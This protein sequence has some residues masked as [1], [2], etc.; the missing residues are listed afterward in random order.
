MSDG[1]ANLQLMWVAGITTVLVTRLYLAATGY[2]KVGNGTLHIAHALWGGLLM[3]A[4][5]IV[6][7]TFTGSFCRRVTALSGG[8]GL[9]LFVDE[10]GKFITQSNDYFFRPAAAVIYVLF[11]I[12]IVITATART[13]RTMSAGA[14]LSAAAAIAATGPA[15]GLT[16]AQRTAILELLDGDDGE[17]AHAVRRFAELSPTRFGRNA[18]RSRA[19][20]LLTAARH[21][22]TQPWF[23]SVVVALFV[24]SRI[25]IDVVFVSR[26]VPLLAGGSAEP[27][28]DGGAIIAAA[29]T[30]TVEAV[31]TVAGAVCWRRRQTAIRLLKAALFVNLCFTQLFNFTDSQFVAIT[32]LPFLI[33]VFLVL[34]AATRGQPAVTPE[35][36]QRPATSTPFN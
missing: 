35:R 2:P 1:G 5:L 18:F 27:G 24:V 3:L 33:L 29:V 13:P 7:L 32:E 20:R 11:A 16:P 36:N 10:V 15:E 4:G 34:S 30:R 14:R 17:A 8:I 22:V 12:L 31:F 6:S 23:L 21:L 25:A 9:G 19:Q 28:H 26:A